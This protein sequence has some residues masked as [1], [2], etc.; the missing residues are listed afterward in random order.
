MSNFRFSSLVL[1]S[2]IL[3]LLT[4]FTAVAKIGFGTPVVPLTPIDE[5]TLPPMGYVKCYTVPASAHFGVWYNKHRICEYENSFFGDAWIDGYWE[6]RNYNSFT[7][8]CSKWHWVKSHWVPHGGHEHGVHPGHH[9][10]K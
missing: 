1:L 9:Y 3:F 6:C 2:G 8:A 10:H 4:S 7:A 5:V